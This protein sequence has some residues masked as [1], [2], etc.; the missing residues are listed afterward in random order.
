MK[1][2]ILS[3]LKNFSMEEFS[4]LL[5]SIEKDPKKF[6]KDLVKDDVIVH[7]PDIVSKIELDDDFANL[8]VGE[9]ISYHFTKGNNP[10]KKL[11]DFYKLYNKSIIPA[12]GFITG[13]FKSISFEQIP[14]HP[15]AKINF[16]EKK[17]VTIKAKNNVIELSL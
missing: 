5:I 13:N 11:V 2:E 15:I 8:K 3:F 6:I 1:K 7:R 10:V 16:S 9:F 12:A 17:N 4:Q 14:E